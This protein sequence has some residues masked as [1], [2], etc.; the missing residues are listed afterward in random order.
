MRPK[1]NVNGE[2]TFDASLEASV[3]IYWVILHWEK[4]NQQKSPKYL[5]SHYELTLEI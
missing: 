1:A 2:V 3:G 4:R 5:E